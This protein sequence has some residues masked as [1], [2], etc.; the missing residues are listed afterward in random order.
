MA[1]E[2]I[3]GRAQVQGTGRGAQRKG[4][5]FHVPDGDTSASEAAALAAPPSIASSAMLALQ[6]TMADPVGER[7]ARRRGQ[8]MLDELTALQRG[9]LGPDGPDPASLRRLAG[10]AASTPASNDPRLRE[11]LE[12]I[13]LRAVV[14]LAR[15]GL[16]G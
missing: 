10:L 4:G 12:A 1:I 6:E 8:D 15:Y 5:S 9:L 13:R 14:E 3:R 7:A 2:G 11:A 16:A